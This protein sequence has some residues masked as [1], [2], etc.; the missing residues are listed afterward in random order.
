LT[1]HADITPLTR[2]R[3][4]EIGFL[5]RAG[6]GKA[7]TLVLLHG[8]GSNAGSFA[9]LMAAL[10]PSIDA[11]A[12]DAPGYGDSRPLALAS[13]AP[14]DY[15]DAVKALLDALGLSRVTVVGH[16][17]GALF[18]A[19]FAAHFS[20]NVAAL[21]LL[22]PALGYRVPAGAPLPP[23]VQARIDE[24]NELGPAAFAAKRA[25]RLVGD[26]LANPQIAA[27]VEKAMAAVH[28]GGYAQA[29]LALGAGDL[30]A[31]VAQVSAPVLVAVGTNDVI[32]PPDN[33][34]TAHGHLKNSV[35]FHLI[36]GAGH[37]LPQDEPAAVAQLLTQLVEEHADV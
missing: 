5:R 23:A 27:A 25:P 28:P 4:A 32:T 2:G 33:A 17:L 26:P 9:A 10:P 29:V 8:V 15:A 37:A 24:I 22:S 19:S 21:A 3:A 20:Q 14:R 16:S 34:R 12:W 35:G 6:R 1:T 30:I 7:R 11:I 36:A 31:D 13:P 18:A